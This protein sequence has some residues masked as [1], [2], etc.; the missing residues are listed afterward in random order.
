MPANAFADIIEPME[1]RSQPRLPMG[2]GWWYEPKWDGF[3]CLAFRSGDEVRL[4]AKS[5]K[6][7][8]RYFPEVI[9]ALK[10]IPAE[11]F[12]IDGELLVAANGAFAF[13]AIQMRLHPAESRIRKL[14]QETPAVLALFDMLED[15]KGRDLRL[16]P[17]HDRRAALVV[18]F[19]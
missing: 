11:R 6:P 9:G 18:F 14:A 5:G 2:E 19:A 16:S 12:V 15:A 13:E 4:Q 3:R 7:L 1:A 8:G 10:A 17:L